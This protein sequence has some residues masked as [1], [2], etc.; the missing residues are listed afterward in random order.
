[1]SNFQRIEKLWILI[2][3]NNFVEHTPTTASEFHNFY[4]RLFIMKTKNPHLERNQHPLSKFVWSNESTV[5]KYA[6]NYS[7]QFVYTSSQV[8]YA[9]NLFVT[10]LEEFLSFV[11]TS[12]NF[13]V[14]PFLG[15]TLE[16]ERE[17]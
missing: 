17:K 9:L 15:M 14:I 6:I 5:I 8:K 16:H 4:N 12:T 10:L 2:F 7:K 3:E 1:M 11:K 13:F